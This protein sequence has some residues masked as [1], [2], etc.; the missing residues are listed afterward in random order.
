MLNI[1]AN[2]ATAGRR[3][4]YFFI[5]LAADTVSPASKNGGQPQISTN[6]A[7]WTNTGIGTLTELG[8]AGNGNG[9]H[10]ADVTQASVATAGDRIR[11]RFKDTDTI[12]TRGEEIVV[13]GYN[14]YS[15]TDLGLSN[16]TNLRVKKNTALNAFEFLMVSSADG[17]S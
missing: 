9:D 10:Y 1:L 8:G 13:V 6:G 15:N 2:E 5:K 17:V 14:P 7:A 3:R 12:E 4:V 16:L 11:T